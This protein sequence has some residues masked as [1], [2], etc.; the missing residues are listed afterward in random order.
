MP[1]ASLVAENRPL[2]NADLIAAYHGTAYKVG[3]GPGPLVLRI[4]QPC[5]E[6]LARSPKFMGGCFITAYN[7]YSQPTP[8][9]DNRKAQR[10]LQALLLDR[11]AKLIEGL[12]QSLDGSW[13]AEPS[14]FVEGL[15]REAGQELAQQFRQNAFVWVG[16]E[17]VPQLVLNKIP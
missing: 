2:P 12:G 16:Q 14:F 17:G 10:Q 13:P 15:S 4:G 1:L 3:E 5:A 6:L 8:E 9:A 7:P 11:G